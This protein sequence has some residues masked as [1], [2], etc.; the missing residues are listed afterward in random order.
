MKRRK[1]NYVGE[2]EQEDRRA[3]TWTEEVKLQEEHRAPL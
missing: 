1:Y 3:C 2:C